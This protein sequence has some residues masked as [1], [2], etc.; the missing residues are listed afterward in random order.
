M[1]CH[2]IPVEAIEFFVKFSQFEYALKR[3][4]G[5][6]E[7]DDSGNIKIRWDLFLQGKRNITALGNESVDYYFDNPPEVFVLGNINSPWQRRQGVKRDNRGLLYLLRQVRNNLFHG[8]KPELVFGGSHGE[9]QRSL[10]LLRHGVTIID[11]FI[12][13]E[14]RI[15]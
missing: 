2:D 13:L 3:I 10:K 6:A 8:E 11:M 1:C 7:Q 4:D 5:Y 9:L 12:E 15:V 14:P